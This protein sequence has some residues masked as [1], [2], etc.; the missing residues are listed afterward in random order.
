MVDGRFFVARFFVDREAAARAAVLRV[1]ALRVAGARLAR[2]RF[3]DVR[4]VD[5]FALF[6]LVRDLL[7]F[8]GDR[9]D[10]ITIVGWLIVDECVR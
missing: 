4:R 9:F 7:R 3:V 2:D 5:L 1:A 10:M 6:A 8:A